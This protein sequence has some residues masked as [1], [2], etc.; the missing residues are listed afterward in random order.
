MLIN[1][2]N[3]SE[4]V[5]A[6]LVQFFTGIKTLK[7]KLDL[8]SG[9]H[10]SLENEDVILCLPDKNYQAI[11]DVCLRF[12]SIEKYQIANEYRTNQRLDA[13]PMKKK[14]DETLL[15]NE[16]TLLVQQSLTLLVNSRT[17]TS[18]IIVLLKLLR[19]ALPRDFTKPIAES[20]L[21]IYI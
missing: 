14:I 13:S 12:C 8:I 19:A 15:Q 3:P 16:V 2:E 1:S 18:V 11:V 6:P 7:G 21:H 4:E 9:I 5:I 17:F 10:K 20:T